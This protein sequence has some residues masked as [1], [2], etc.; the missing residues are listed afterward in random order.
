VSQQLAIVVLVDV[1]AALGSG[2]LNGNMYL[3]DNMGRQ[4][5]HG[6]GTGE[7]VTAVNGSHWFDGAQA[8]E[9]VLNW[10]VYSLGSIPPTVPRGY[11]ASRAQHSDRQAIAA[12]GDLATRCGT[13]G[14]DVTAELAHI[15]RSAG[16]RVGVGSA[17]HGSV[18]GGYP[19]LDV[20]GEIVP[21]DPGDTAPAHSHPHPVITDITGEA[22]DRSIMFPA[23]YGSPDVVTDGWYWSATVDTARPGTYAYTMTIKLHRLVRDGGEWVLRPV[24]LAYESRIRIT[25]A[26]RRNGFTRAGLG[27]LPIPPPTRSGA[28][29]PEVAG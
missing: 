12:L 9:Q 19:M 16:T 27:M 15:H 14:T 21:R 20:T 2:S 4:G 13:P 3:I 29:A 25:T 1:G 7:L 28:A 11:H 23:A 18:H 5:S 10:L 22:V 24:Y 26:P 8:D 17:R 6:E